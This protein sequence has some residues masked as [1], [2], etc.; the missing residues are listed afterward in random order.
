[1]FNIIETF[2]DDFPNFNELVI[3]FIKSKVNSD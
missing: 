3:K 2:K 1:M